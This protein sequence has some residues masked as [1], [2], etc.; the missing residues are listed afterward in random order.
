MK[1]WIFAAMVSLLFPV[2]ALA[3]PPDDWVQPGTE[4]TAN[5]DSSVDGVTDHIV[6]L[7]DDSWTTTA[8]FKCRTSKCSCNLVQDQA[9]SGGT[10]L[11]DLWA[12]PGA[13]ATYSTTT[14]PVLVKSFTDDDY[15]NVTRGDY[16][17]ENTAAAGSGDEAIFSCRGY[18]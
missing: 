16:L 10:A 9:A 15:V 3:A 18:E 12:C 17:I 11:V 1:R 7:F 14:C 2:V 13:P 8:S 4:T 5:A 6:F